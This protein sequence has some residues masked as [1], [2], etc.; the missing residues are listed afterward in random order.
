MPN[1]IR[2]LS[3]E[4][5]STIL[6]GKLV[7]LGAA[8]PQ[9]GGEFKT[10]IQANATALGIGPQVDSLLAKA[11]GDPNAFVANAEA[12]YDDQMDRVS[13]WYKLEAQRLLLALG[14][15][16]AV[17][18]NVDSARLIRAFSCDAALRSGLAG[19]ATQ[20]AGGGAL[21]P[22]NGAQALA[23]VLSTVPLGWS[24]TSPP[25]APLA[26]DPTAKAA[27]TNGPLP[28]LLEKILGLALTAIALSLGAPFWFDVLSRVTRVRLSGEKP[29]PSSAS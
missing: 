27:R 6:M 5:F 28:W 19:A 15:A 16:M 2:Y 29:D 25:E 20:T 26:C 22:D 24:L 7:P 18:F 17:L 10:Q 13:G 21:T 3:A 12:W 14:L 11:N 4:Q 8:L 1:A 9:I 23:D